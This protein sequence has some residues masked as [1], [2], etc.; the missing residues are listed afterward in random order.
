MHK[1]LIILFAS[2]LC[3]CGSDTPAPA[4]PAQPRF[5]LLDVAG[6]SARSSDADACVTDTATGLVWERKSDVQGLHDWRNTYS[7]YAPDEPHDELDYRGTQAAGDCDGSRCDTHDVVRMV[8]EERYCGFDDW[9]IPLRDELFSISDL[10]KADNP[11]TVDTEAFPLTHAAE[12]WSANDYSFQ[13]ESAWAWNFQFGHD[14][15]DWKKTPKFLRL[16]R[17]TATE[18][19][20]VKE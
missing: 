16:V 4:G 11:P 17:G 3:A 19:T 8:N 12:Y 18:L 10:R 7:W 13:P 2:G 9:R 14:R 15:V 20:A 1:K 5:Q 6:M